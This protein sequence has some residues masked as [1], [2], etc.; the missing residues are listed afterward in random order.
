MTIRPRSERST[1]GPSTSPTR[2]GRPVSI[3]ETDKLTGSFVDRDA[4]EAV[5]DRLETWS[6]LVFDYLEPAEAAESAAPTAS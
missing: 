4:V 6:R 5:A 3:R 2:P 1:S